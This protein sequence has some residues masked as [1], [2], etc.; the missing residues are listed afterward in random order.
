MAGFL[1]NE[2]ER[3]WKEVMMEKFEVVCQHCLEGQ[4]KS[5]KNFCQGSLSLGHDLNPGPPKS[6]SRSANRELLNHSV[7]Y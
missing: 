5:K 6:K 7:S 3:M 4:R 1:G 2:L